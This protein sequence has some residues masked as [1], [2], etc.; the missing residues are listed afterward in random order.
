MHCLNQD[1]FLQYSAT[2][3]CAPMKLHFF[4]WIYCQLSTSSA[5][6]VTLAYHKIA[7]T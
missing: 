7:E 1:A 5:H 6:I 2:Y 4:V 3:K